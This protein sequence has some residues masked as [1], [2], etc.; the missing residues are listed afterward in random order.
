MSSSSTK[1]LWIRRRGART[2]RCSTTATAA[3]SIR[4]GRVR[5]LR[6]GLIPHALSAA[7]WGPSHNE[8]G[9]LAQQ[10]IGN[11]AHTLAAFGCRMQSHHDRPGREVCRETR[12]F[13]GWIPGTDGHRRAQPCRHRGDELAEVLMGERPAARF[14][15][16]GATRG[17]AVSR[18]ERRRR[19][20]SRGPGGS[21]RPSSP[22]RG[23][24]RPRRSD[25]SSTVSTVIPP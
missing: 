24:Q 3:R 13:G 1:T 2:S 21:G 11:G 22:R 12:E 25:G 4:C 8:H 15:P 16:S 14:R 10:P 18:P 5:G 7:V 17:G 19:Q 6:P 20:I 9:R 23:Q